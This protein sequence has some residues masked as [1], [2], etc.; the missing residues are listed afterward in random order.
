MD[1]DWEVL[2][3]S[4]TGNWVFMVMQCNAMQCNVAPFSNPSLGLDPNQ[5][6][7]K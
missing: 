2:D 3:L 7:L 4:G 5:G 1:R 6:V